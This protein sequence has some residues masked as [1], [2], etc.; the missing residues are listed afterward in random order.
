MKLAASS[1]TLGVCRRRCAA[2]LGAVLLASLTATAGVALAAPKGVWAWG[3]NDW[4]QLG[5]GVRSSS[6]PAQLVSGLTEPVAVAAGHKHSLALLSN[7]TVMA[8]GANEY[9]Q[10]GNGTLAGSNA[11]VEVTGLGEV[12]AISAGSGF[13][14]ALRRNGTVMAWGNN[15]W[16]QLGNGTQVS[17][18]VPVAV[19]GLSE[20]AAISAG[21]RFSIAL[22]RNGTVEMWGYNGP[23]HEGGEL[24]IGTA[25]APEVCAN[26]PIERE[27]PPHPALARSR[28]RMSRGGRERVYCSTTPVHVI[29][30]S[31][32]T[33]IAAGCTHSL[34]LLAN[35]EVAGWGANSYGELGKG[36]KKLDAGK[37]RSWVPV[38]MDRVTEAVGVS[39]GDKYSLL[40]LRN[41]TAIGAGKNVSGELGDGTNLTKRR[42]SGVVGLTGVTAVSA[43]PGEGGADH[44][45]A[46]LSNGTVMAWGKNSKEDLGDGSTTPSYVPVLVHGLAGAT[47]IS[48]GGI[49]HS[50]AL[51]PTK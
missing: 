44:S 33:A 11:P 28:A 13:N 47:A 34:A 36:N 27:P 42:V 2:V 14:L 31:G 16:G 1:S 18:A 22:M 25:T 4:G 8:W 12:A 37:N 51:A 29:E 41:G 19:K 21:R 45:L 49:S 10:L 24:G 30:L 23:A 38:H 20:V 7:G 50:L 48:A 17:S 46:L 15:Q 35:G 3:G 6:G 39:A 32:V 26:A 43:G 9:G 40:V 5:N